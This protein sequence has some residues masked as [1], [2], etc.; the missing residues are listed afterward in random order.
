MVSKPVGVLSRGDGKQ[1]RNHC[2]FR[3]SLRRDSICYRK[4]LGG[5][6]VRENENEKKS[7]DHHPTAERR[8]FGKVRMVF[9]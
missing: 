5:E 3:A 7:R 2:K 1:P 8:R 6:K 9:C 4:R